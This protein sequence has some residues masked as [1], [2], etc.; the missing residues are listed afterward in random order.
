MMKKFQEVL[1]QYADINLDADAWGL[2]A[3]EGKLPNGVADSIRERLA[4][5]MNKSFN[6]LLRQS[7]NRDAAV[8]KICKQIDSLADRMDFNTYNADSTDV[9][10][11]V[12]REITARY[13]GRLDQTLPNELK[14]YIRKITQVY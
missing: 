1:G 9:Y 6:T 14:L 2:L 12:F 7:L 11:I 13:I 10:E 3:C 8:D 5:A 4:Q